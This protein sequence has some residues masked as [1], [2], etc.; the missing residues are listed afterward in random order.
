[1]ARFG[2]AREVDPN[3]GHWVLA[4]LEAWFGGRGADPA[5]PV[6]APG[7]F[8]LYTQNVD[9]LHERAGSQAVHHLHGSIHRYRCNAC[10][11]PHPLREED[12]AAETPPR[13]ARC[14]N[15]VRPDV[16][17]FGEA[18]PLEVLASAERAARSCEAMLV[19]GTSGLVYPAAG[20]PQ[21]ALRAGASVVEVN[22]EETPISRSAEV[23]LQ[24]P[25]GAMLPAVLDAL[26]A[27]PA[28]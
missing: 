6:R 20:L 11:A 1:M 2:R 19:V 4:R 3:P 5:L 12:R 22:P 8:A 27:W 26:A 18:L 25:S 15:L 24:G 9:D 21:L 23:F 14:G 28:A 7:S 10:E 16:V 17:W 13:C